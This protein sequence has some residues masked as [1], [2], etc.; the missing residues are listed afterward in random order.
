MVTVI[1]VLVAIN[2]VLVGRLMVAVAAD[3]RAERARHRKSSFL[4]G[5]K[6]EF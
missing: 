1:W 4:K 2:V 5:W 6:N 3:E